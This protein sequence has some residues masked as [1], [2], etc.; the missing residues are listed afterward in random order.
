M[1]FIL[2]V[3][4]WIISPEEEGGTGKMEQE[5]SLGELM[6]QINSE[7]Q[8]FSQVSFIY[9]IHTYLLFREVHI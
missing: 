4:F 2:L 6:D 9:C 3:R 7:G 1:I 5:V 8:Y